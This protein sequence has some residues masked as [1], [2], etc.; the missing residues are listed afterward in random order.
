MYNELHALCRLVPSPICPRGKAHH[1]RQP[2]PSNKPLAV[3]SVLTRETA[4]WESW[5]RRISLQFLR[6]RR[7]CLN[8]LELL[9]V[10]GSCQLMG[11]IISSVQDLMAL[12]KQTNT[13]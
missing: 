1:L 6:P 9:R 3:R 8:C 10:G 2:L 5:K 11:R 7:I 13:H 4:H 12:P